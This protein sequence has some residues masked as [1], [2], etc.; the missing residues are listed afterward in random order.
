MQGIFGGAPM[1]FWPFLG[2]VPFSSLPRVHVWSHHKTLILKSV[3]VGKC[4]F[5]LVLIAFVRSKRWHFWMTIS[6]DDIRINLNRS[7]LKSKR[8]NHNGNVDSAAWSFPVTLHD[9]GMKML[10][11]VKSRTN[12]GRDAMSNFGIRTIAGTGV[13]FVWDC[14]Y[15]WTCAWVS[16]LRRAAPD[17]ILWVLKTG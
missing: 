1:H 16:K 17:T 8:K 15:L 6:F 10:T 13:D 14:C 7:P 5:T 12:V 3:S 4:P 9:A 11:L 2:A